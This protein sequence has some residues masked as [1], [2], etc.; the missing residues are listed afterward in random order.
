MPDF[1]VTSCLFIPDNISGKTPAI[2]HV[3][4]HAGAA[5]R[6]EAYQIFI[7]NLVRKGFI[8]FAI[9]PVGQGGAASVL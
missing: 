5:F 7:L 8:V 9:D 4:G 6:S 2:V 3:S 1:Y